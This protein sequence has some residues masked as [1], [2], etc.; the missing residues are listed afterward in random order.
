MNQSKSGIAWGY[1][2]G[3][4]LAF[5]LGV[6]FLAYPLITNAVIG[7]WF[8]AFFAATGVVCIINYITGN[9]LMVRSGWSL[10]TGI[11]DT[12]IGIL[13]IVFPLFASGMLA[14]FLG[15]FIIISAIFMLANGGT[16]IRSVSTGLFILNVI[17]AIL[18][19]IVGVGMIFNQSMMTTFFGFFAIFKGIDLIIEGFMH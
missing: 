1:V 9:G 16:A 15:V 2:V 4:I 13:F 5:F 3:G 17:M 14:V 11:L 18:F 10:A 7:I 19:I 6:F 8:G 12:L